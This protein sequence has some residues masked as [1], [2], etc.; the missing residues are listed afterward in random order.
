MY[1]LSPPS[2]QDLNMHDHQI[3]KAINSIA[4]I[5]DKDSFGT[6]GAVKACLIMENMF[7]ET[8]RINKSPVG[9]EILIYANNLNGEISSLG[10]Y[11]NELIQYVSKEKNCLKIIFDEEP[12]ECVGLTNAF[13]V[14][15]SLSRSGK[16]HKNIKVRQ[17][18]NRELIHQLLNKTLPNYGADYF[19]VS[20][21]NMYRVETDSKKHISKASFNDKNI[22][23]TLRNIFTIIH[24]KYSKEY[25]L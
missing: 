4:L 17:T 7:R 11:V 24:E 12:K 14:L 3:E 23:E 9:N 8:G 20:S 13:F 16:L 21:E 6:I 2:I 22:S 15:K 10:N 1:S 25:T 18:T 5:R 19:S